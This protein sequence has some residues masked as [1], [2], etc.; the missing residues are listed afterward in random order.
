MTIDVT[1]Y[2]LTSYTMSQRLKASLSFGGRLWYGVCLIASVPGEDEKKQQP[3]DEVV[4]EREEG[5]ESLGR[6]A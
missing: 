2:Y 1:D 6:L 4:L 3:H 5:D